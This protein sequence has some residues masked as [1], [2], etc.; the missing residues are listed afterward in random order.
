MGLLVRSTAPGGEPSLPSWL[1]ELACAA[2]AAA[3]ASWR[4]RKYLNA[5]HQY[6]MQDFFLKTLNSACSQIWRA[7]FLGLIVVRA[8][9]AE[10]DAVLAGRLRVVLVVACATNLAGAAGVTTWMG[11]RHG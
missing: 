5:R 10:C 3:A 4:R 6:K 2:A 9:D 11:R 7:A 8:W 1:F